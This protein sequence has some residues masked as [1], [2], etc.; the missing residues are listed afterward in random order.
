[1]PRSQ[2]ADPHADVATCEAGPAP[3]DAR[4]T[5]LLV[6]G[7]GASAE[8]MFG[9]FRTLHVDGV[10]AI[11]PQ[12]A[13][14][15]WYPLP[16]LAPVR[17]NQPYLDFALARL[18]ACVEDLM[19]RGIASESV[20]LLG[21]SQGACL[22]CEFVARHPRRYG[23]V[24]GLSGGLIGPP[25]TPRDYRG[26]LSGTP[27]LLGCADPDAH[28]PFQRVEETAKVLRRMGAIVDL[29]RYLGLGHT[30][31][32]DELE[33]CRAL[34]HGIIW[35]SAQERTGRNPGFLDLPKRQS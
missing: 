3:T 26:S 24:M 19:D 14:H 16:F 2:P 8:S 28:I 32:Q 29:R 17:D 34:I 31:N 22:V 7:R 9:I 33:A 13:G 10:A 4:A 20:A 6:H 23:A 30:V 15:S 35:S 21:F 27:V 11:A 18:N 1:M 12:A 25:G 5:L